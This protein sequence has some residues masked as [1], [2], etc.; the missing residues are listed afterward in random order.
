MNKKENRAM[1]IERARK[2]PETIQVELTS[3]C[4]LKCPQCYN[5]PA[6]REIN[7]D[8]L[9]EYIKEAAGLEVRMITL[10]GGEPLLYPDLD[11][12]IELV[13]ASG[14]L[15]MISTSG[16][17]L[18]EKR[19][20]ELKKAGLSYIWVSLN[21]ST[22]DIHEKS[23]DGYHYA[24]EALSR[25]KGT[26]LNYGIN[27]VARKDNT[28]DF[29]NLVNLARQMKAEAITV[30]R[31]KPDSKFHATEASLDGEHLSRLGAYIKSCKSD[32]LSIY[33][34]RCFSLLRTVMY[35][36]KVLYN[37][38]RAGRDF[39]AI[40]ASG[41]F[42]PC[43]HLHYGEKMPG[44]ESY[45]NNSGLLDRLR[46]TEEKVEY[47]CRDCTHLPHCR[48][49][50]ATCEKLYGSFYAGEQNCP[51]FEERGSQVV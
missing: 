36:D 19:I 24:M 51:L 15:S 17:G 45:W 2:A 23:R 8:L 42:I 37:G 26:G 29:L 49:C 20:G 4:P 43:M 12:I 40:S 18:S 7:R 3:R 50:R 38:C 11:Y 1:I 16:I 33:I 30:L 39:M 10:S 13:S 32:D 31:L 48:T 46:S 5:D 22:R 14:M 28:D 21:G 41:D 47:P 6:P 35:G 25:L 9:A 27:W 34:D 44:L